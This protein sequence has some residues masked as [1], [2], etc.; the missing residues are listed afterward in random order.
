MFA[1]SGK[2]RGKSMNE[3]NESALTFVMIM[4]KYLEM[5]VAFAY[6]NCREKQ[7]HHNKTNIVK[8]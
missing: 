7:K 6:L 2:G 3:E 1:C 5:T 8:M 4:K